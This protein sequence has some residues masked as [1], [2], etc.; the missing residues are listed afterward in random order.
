[1]DDSNPNE[2]Y[3]ELAARHGFPKSKLLALIFR[4]MVTPDQAKL[5]LQLPDTEPEDIPGNLG[6]TKE[7]VDSH[8][9]EMFEKLLSSEFLENMGL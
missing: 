3:L 9:Q 5:L 8:L 2:L 7:T 1:M 4:K 6:L